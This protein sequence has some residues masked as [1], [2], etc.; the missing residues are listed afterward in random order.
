MDHNSPP[1]FLSS[2]SRYPRLLMELSLEVYPMPYDTYEM[3]P[4]RHLDRGVRLQINEGTRPPGCQDGTRYSVEETNQFHWQA[5]EDER[6]GTFSLLRRIT[7]SRL[8]Y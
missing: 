3:R 8:V 2:D 1:S 6:M 4:H 5:Q 7:V